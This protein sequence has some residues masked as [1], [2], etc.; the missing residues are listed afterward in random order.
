VYRDLTQPFLRN[1]GDTGFNPG[2]KL[3]GYYQTSLWDDWDGDQLAPPIFK[4][5]L[6]YGPD[7]VVDFLHP[8]CKMMQMRR[9]I[10]LDAELEA[11]LSD[12][13][14]LIK[15]K[16]AVVIRQALRA[17]LPTVANRFQSPR[18]VGYFA[19]DYGQ[20]KELVALEL[21][22]SKVRQKPER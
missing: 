12:A 20:D 10:N 2:N 5:C 13:V 1:S 18:P 7:R 17:G 8:G 19:E 9:T 21:G 3:P 4:Y 11:E 14:S 16:P 22:M 15:E 6:C